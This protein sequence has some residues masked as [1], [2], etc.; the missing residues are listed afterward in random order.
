MMMMKKINKSQIIIG[1]SV[2]F[3]FLSF[4]FYLKKDPRTKYNG[5]YLIVEKG[6]EFSLIT[7][8]QIKIAVD[9]VPI[10]GILDIEK[11][12]MAYINYPNDPQLEIQLT[13]NGKLKFAKLTREN[14]G[15]PLAIIL[16]DMLL[17]VPIVETEIP[18]GKIG[19]SGLD[20]KLVR[21]LAQRFKK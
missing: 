6:K 15:K 14:I 17:S 9:S 19:V 5:I 16:D 18:N 20:K 10:V 1:L 11:V 2:L 4:S 13:E 3:G 8:K 21:T 12:R 7:Q